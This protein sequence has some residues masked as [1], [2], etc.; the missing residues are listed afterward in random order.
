MASELS[1]DA[2]HKFAKYEDLIP[3][4]VVNYDLS[5]FQLFTNESLTSGFQ[6]QSDT[7]YVIFDLAVA[8]WYHHLIPGSILEYFYWNMAESTFRDALGIVCPVLKDFPF[9]P[10]RNRIWANW[11]LM[12]SA[13]KLNKING[14]NV[15]RYLRLNY[16]YSKGHFVVILPVYFF[17][18]V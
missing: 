14:Q 11:E 16:R 18:H 17:E 4:G 15:A 5:K 7:K 13:R 8:K 9:T 2:D 1:N 12:I 3:S 10:T 6:L